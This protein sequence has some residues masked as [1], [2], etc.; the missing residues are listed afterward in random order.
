MHADG[1]WGDI[2]ATSQREGE[3]DREGEEREREQTEGREEMEARLPAGLAMLSQLEPFR[4]EEAVEPA[5][6]PRPQRKRRVPP[7]PSP[8]PVPPDVQAV[9]FAGPGGRRRRERKIT[10]SPGH[11]W[12]NTQTLGGAVYASQVFGGEEAE[13]E[14][15]AA[16]GQ[17]DG[18]TGGGEEEWKLGGGVERS[19]APSQVR[20]DEQCDV[21][22]LAPAHFAGC[23]SA[24]RAYTLRPPP[25]SHTR[26]HTALALSSLIIVFPAVAVYVQDDAAIPPLPSVR[27]VSRTRR[28]LEEDPPP[29]AVGV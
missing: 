24:A 12:V 8:P 15:K 7:P 28:L 22:T 6:H 27:R 14:E 10:S 17:E 18:N 4:E 5:D 21:Y 25:H 11:V 1:D 2:A 29:P 3:E 13:G 9:V 26:T 20:L 23:V 16:A 19:S